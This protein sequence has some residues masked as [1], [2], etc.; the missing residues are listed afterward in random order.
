VIGAEKEVAD[1][2]AGD[3]YTHKMHEKVRKNTT[4]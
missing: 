2:D 4:V 3:E 1:G